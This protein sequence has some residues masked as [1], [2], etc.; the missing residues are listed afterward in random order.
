MARAWGARRAASPY[1]GPG[2][3]K[4]ADG[5]GPH[6]NAYRRSAPLRWLRP[7]VRCVVACL[8]R[9]LRQT[10]G[11]APHGKQTNKASQPPGAMQQAGTILMLRR[12]VDADTYVC[13]KETGRAQYSTMSAVHR[14]IFFNLRCN[15]TKFGGVCKEPTTV[16]IIVVV[17]VDV[18]WRVL[19]HFST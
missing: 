13:G 14:G 11:L 17:V 12:K 7:Y 5:L 8:R 2:T 19:A 1:L 18:Y 9:H 10:N 3:A 16:C 6:P 4:R 15:L